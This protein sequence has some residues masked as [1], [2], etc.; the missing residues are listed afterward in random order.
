MN[1][2]T[3]FEESLRNAKSHETFFEIRG[4]TWKLVALLGLWE[5]AHRAG[6][7]DFAGTD[8][9]LSL[10]GC[11]HHREPTQA[12]SLVCSKYKET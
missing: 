6:V 9:F 12:A 8:I 5:M 7:G 4:I 10:G 2:K 1:C 11:L 3:K